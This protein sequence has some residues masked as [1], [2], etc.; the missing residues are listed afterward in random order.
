MSYYTPTTL[1]QPFPHAAM[2]LKQERG[3]PAA[4]PQQTF[5]IPGLVGPGQGPPGVGLPQVEGRPPSADVGGKKH[6]RE[7]TTFTYQQLAILEELYQRTKYPDVFVREE[8]SL[9]TKLTE[10][11][12]VVWFKNRRAKDRNLTIKNQGKD[13]SP[14]KVS[15]SVPHSNNIPVNPEKRSPPVAIKSEVLSPSKKSNL[16]M[17]KALKSEKFSPSK[18]KSN[19]YTVPTSTVPPNKTIYNT[20]AMNSNIA[21]SSNNRYA[22]PSQNAKLYQYNQYI[23]RYNM[24]A[25]MLPSPSIPYPM[26]SSANN[27]YPMFSSSSNPYNKNYQV[28]QQPVVNKEFLVSRPPAVTDEFEPILLTLLHQAPE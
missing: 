19:N 13:K 5:A 2:Y 24:L 16:D 27:P 4:V 15:Q 28:N 1:T 8:V 3:V 21:P 25:S 18:V 7:R 20:S 22:S 26:L 10:S 12:V 17:L 6:R 14:A 9:K 23:S 11:K